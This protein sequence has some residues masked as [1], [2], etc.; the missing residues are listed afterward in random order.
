MAGKRPVVYWDTNVYVDW[1]NDSRAGTPQGDGIRFWY[2]LITARDVVLIYSQI[3]WLE[4]SA[5]NVGP[6]AYDRF[7]RFVRGFGTAWPVDMRVITEANRLREQ[8]VGF[9]HAGTDDTVICPPDAIHLASANLAEC[10]RFFTFDR[11]GRHGCFGLLPFNG[12]LAGFVPRIIEPGVD[13]TARPRRHA[14]SL[15][16]VRE[17]HPSLFGGEEAEEPADDELGEDE[18]V[19]LSELEAGDGT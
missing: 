14:P 7:E 15:A 13:P 16:E 12:R 18:D 8:S 17:A 10:S 19:D 4:V 1:L 3:L 11:N 9:R 2:D 5:L 6:V